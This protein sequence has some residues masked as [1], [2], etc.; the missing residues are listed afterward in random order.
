M[1]AAAA[2]QNAAV[3]ATTTAAAAYAVNGGCYPNTTA[4]AVAANAVANNV[5]NQIGIGNTALSQLNF[6]QR[7]FQRNFGDNI[8]STLRNV[9]NNTNNGNNVGNNATTNGTNERS[10]IGWVKI[11]NVCNT[12]YYSILGLTW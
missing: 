7:S 1:A 6:F 4:T 8:H 9:N 3:A 2:Q 5:V 12:S 10:A 11:S